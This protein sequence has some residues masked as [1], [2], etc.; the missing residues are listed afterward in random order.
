[1]QQKRLRRDDGERGGHAVV[2]RIEPPGLGVGSAPELISGVPLHSGQCA[3]RRLKNARIHMTRLNPTPPRIT[4]TATGFGFLKNIT[5]AV[6]V[7]IS[8][9]K[10]SAEKKTATLKG[11]LDGRERARRDPR[12]R[13]RQVRGA[14]FRS[15]THLAPKSSDS[16]RCF[17]SLE[18]P[19]TGS[20][21]ISAQSFS[22]LL[23]AAGRGF[24]TCR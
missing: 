1:M 9:R 19:Q 3:S 16:P 17:T 24:T 5:T 7:V 20:I 12:P 14:V 13:V 18:F 4:F 15:Q 10:C 23:T 22:A 11:R 8:P 2:E 21:R 6:T